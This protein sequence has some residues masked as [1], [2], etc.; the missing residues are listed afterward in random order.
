[1]TT[2]SDVQQFLKT[3]LD[4]IRFEVNE[5]NQR[6]QAFRLPTLTESE[7]HQ[8][9]TE[10]A[11]RY[12]NTGIIRITPGA[13]G[14]M[15]Y[16]FAGQL[17]QVAQEH[18]TEA[19]NKYLDEQ[20][21]LAELKQYK[22][23]MPISEFV[24]SLLQSGV[25]ADQKKWLETFKRCVLP[26]KVRS[27][28]EEAL[29]MVLLSHKFDEWG[30]NEAF[31]KGLTNSILLYGPPGT[32]K[33]MIAESF[34]AV[35]GKNLLKVDT[36]TIQSQIPG[37]AERN[38]KSNFEKAGEEN[39]VLMF[40][41]CDSLLYNRDAV[42]AIMAAEINCLLTELE[43]FDGVVILTTNRLGRLDPALQRRIIAKIE[44][45]LPGKK[46]R[47]QIWKNL[48]PPKMP[49][50]DINFETLAKETISGG[51]IK[52]AILLAARKAI[53]LNAT[54][55]EME[56]LE[57]ALSNVVQSK[58]DFEHA[59][60]QVVHEFPQEAMGKTQSMTRSIQRFKAL[61]GAA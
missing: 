51:D 52:N 2:F 46:E 41:E 39:A 29:T 20:K 6:R 19:Q 17:A 48:M 34:A 15:A 21:R 40:D 10:M 44:L 38:I 26:P 23:G 61:G 32:G 12:A 16:A 28:I 9:V 33:T 42:G 56:H 18:S 25:D 54:K 36:A 3:H 8:A 31:E 57:I 50:G 30:I 27:M 24:D 58:K 13:T 14:Q 60:P 7:I 55:V 49:V 11:K 35:L 22:P 59:Q 1:M 4:K 53:T 5:E 37:E 45:G 47:L 43:R